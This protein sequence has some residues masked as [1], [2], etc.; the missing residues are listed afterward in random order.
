VSENPVNFIDP[1]GLSKADVER[2]LK[3]ARGATE[4]LT[5]NGERTDPGGWNNFVSSLQRVNPWNKKRYLGCGEQ[6]DRVTSDVQ[7]EQYD[8]KWTFGIEQ[9]GPFH[10]RG[11]AKSSNPSDPDIIYDPWKKEFFTIPKGTK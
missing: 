9:T 7:F 3:L 11:R 2:I 5:K 8:D 1:P 10:Q 4:R 6:A